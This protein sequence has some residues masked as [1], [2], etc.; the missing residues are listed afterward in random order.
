M[1]KKPKKRSPEQKS[2]SLVHL[3]NDQIVS[4]LVAEFK[5]FFADYIDEIGDLDEPWHLPEHSVDDAAAVAG[6]ASMNALVR[7]AHV[8]SVRNRR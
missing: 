3:T 7:A 5:R 2:D 1:A 4:Q 8:A 6:R